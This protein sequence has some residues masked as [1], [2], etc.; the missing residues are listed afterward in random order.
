MKLLTGGE[1]EEFAEL[2]FDVVWS[3]FSS[4][5]LRTAMLFMDLRLKLRLVFK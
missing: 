2:F 3:W 1:L 4:V 5:Q